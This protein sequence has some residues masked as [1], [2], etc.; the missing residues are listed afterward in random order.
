MKEAVSQA[1][2]ELKAQFDGR[3]QVEAQPDG[4]AR[5]VIDGITLGPPYVQAD[6]WIGFTLVPV[7]PYADVY[8]H[9]VRHDLARLDGMPLQRPLHIN[10]HFYGRPAVLV[11]RKTRLFGPANPNHAT[12]KLLKVQAWLL[13]L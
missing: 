8:P 1:I 9:F 4:G 2:E 10:N 6:T 11:S 12:L 5:V 13:S 7:Y 3:V